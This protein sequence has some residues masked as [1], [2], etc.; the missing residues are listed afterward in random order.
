VETSKLNS[1]RASSDLSAVAE[2]HV[3]N[4]LAGGRTGQEALQGLSGQEAVRL[5]EDARDVFD[6]AF[7]STLKLSALIAIAGAAVAYSIIPRLPSPAP[8]EIPVET[9]IRPEG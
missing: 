3:H 8:A 2:T 1:D 9:Q 4:L 5:T 7:A 6:A